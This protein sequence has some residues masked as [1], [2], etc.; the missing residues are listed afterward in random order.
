MSSKMGMFWL[1][2]TVD[3]EKVT[4]MLLE[5]PLIEPMLSLV[6]QVKV[7]ALLKPK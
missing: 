4:D 1:H 2:P 6:D 5:L 3:E 7:L